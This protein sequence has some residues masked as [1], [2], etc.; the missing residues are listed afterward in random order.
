MSISKVIESYFI[1]VLHTYCSVS[2]SIDFRKFL[3]ISKICISNLQL[4][5]IVKK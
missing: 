2:R 4:L 3:R 1:I 5:L